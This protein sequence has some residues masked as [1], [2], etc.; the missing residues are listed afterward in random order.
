MSSRPTNVLKVLD[1]G[2]ASNDP[3][4]EDDLTRQDDE[5]VLSTAD[6]LSPVQVIDSHRVDSRA[7]AYSLDCT[8]YFL[9]TGHLRFPDGLLAQRILAH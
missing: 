6:Y 1:L 8:L 5:R 9:L 7:D 4:D 3:S 2:L